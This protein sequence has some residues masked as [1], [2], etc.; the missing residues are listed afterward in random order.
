MVSESNTDIL[1]NI[2]SDASLFEYF[3][4]Y[5]QQPTPKSH[6][7]TT[8]GVVIKSDIS[9]FALNLSIVTRG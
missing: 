5:M 9:N 2:E 1:Y 8:V 3:R 6:S 7:S 4:C